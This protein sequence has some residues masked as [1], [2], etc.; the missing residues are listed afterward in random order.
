MGYVERGPWNTYSYGAWEFRATYLC[1]ECHR[2]CKWTV[3]QRRYIGVTKRKRDTKDG[4][5]YKY[6]PWVRFKKDKF[7]F[8]GQTTAKKAA[9]I[10]D[11]AK[12][13]LKINGRKGFN[14]SQEQ[15]IS[16]TQF[17]EFLP[18]Q[19]D[20]DIKRLVL[21]YAQPFLNE[22]QVSEEVPIV[23]QPPCVE[24]ARFANGEHIDNTIQEFLPSDE[25]DNLIQELYVH[26]DADGQTTDMT[27]E[28]QSV[29]ANPESAGPA[30][31]ENVGEGQG[32]LA[33]SVDP[34][35]NQPTCTSKI[36]LMAPCNC[37]A[38]MSDV[39]VFQREKWQV[40][41]FKF[42]A[43][44]TSRRCELEGCSE[45][46]HDHICLQKSGHVQELFWSDE[47]WAVFNHLK[48]HGWQKVP[49]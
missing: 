7:Y 25:V 33:L 11:V 14:F 18:Q 46:M 47:M 24:P 48:K 40:A 32:V 9:I 20:N 34:S 31:E 26:V 36:T 49:F 3:A 2:D 42:A 4:S 19:P 16:L 5:I 39:E 6:E 29:S 35:L 43:S 8:E 44:N 38:D 37:I 22:V 1:G 41:T 10:R 15:Y 21:L 45:I 13:C 23:D 12:F 17:Q 27:E 30:I 28:P